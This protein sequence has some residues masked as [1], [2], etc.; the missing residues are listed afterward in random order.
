MEIRLTKS[1]LLSA[2]SLHIYAAAK[3]DVSD[4]L[5]FL[6]FKQT[7]N[8]LDVMATDRYAAAWGQYDLSGGTIH[9]DTDPFYVSV[10]D[11]KLLMTFFKNWPETEFIVLDYRGF[12]MGDGNV[13]PWSKFPHSFPPIERLFGKETGPAP[14]TMGMRVSMIAKLDK[15]VLPSSGKQDRDAAW[16]LRFQST[17]TDKP[18]PVECYR[19]GEK[20]HITV[21]LQPALLQ[22]L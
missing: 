4:G 15:L 3:R 7:A 18:G 9:T 13:F 20:G 6:Q 12:R 14:E 22:N 8:K 19:P 11:A 10:E 16:R 2:L 5:K 21:L 17:G 1:Q